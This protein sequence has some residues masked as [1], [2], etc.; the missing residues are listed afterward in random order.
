MNC[1]LPVAQSGIGPTSVGFLALPSGAFQADAAPG[2]V[3][4]AGSQR[5]KTTQGPVLYGDGGATYDR[6]N[7]RWVPVSSAQV[8]SDGSA[9]VYTREA[10]PTQF[11][12]EIHLVSVATATDRII[13]NGG[14][15][16]ALAYRPEGVYLVHHLNGTDASQ[17]LWLLDPATGSVK[18]FTSGARASW[19]AIAAGG[20]W[21][22]SVDGSRFGSSSLARLDLSSD[23]VATWLTVAS[24]APP[25]EAGSRTVHAMSFDRDGHPIVEVY[26]QAGTPEVWLVSAPG[27]ATRL[28]GL[29]LG[30]NMPQPGITDSNGAWIVGADGVYLYK[31]S[32]FQRL[33]SA[34]PGWT[35]NYT[36]AGPCS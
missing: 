28:T 8:L 22:F 7:G 10:S 24:P 9:Y 4:D 26:V 16:D 2:I 25:G 20:A 19:A 3:Y 12:N 11:V 5:T 35:A 15:Y 33:A 23:T 36:V 14:A 6:A 32:S 18:A 29:A 34:P 13:Y 30:P 17:G 27:Q 1:K 31:G 21:S